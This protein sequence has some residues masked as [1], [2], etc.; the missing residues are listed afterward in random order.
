MRRGF[1]LVELI[2]VIVIVAIA[3]SVVLPVFQNRC[4]EPAR[5]TACA[6]NLGQIGKAL[7]MYSDVPSNGMFPTCSTDKND[8]YSDPNPMLALN[9][10]YR[11]YVAD[12]RVFS[13]SRRADVAGKTAGARI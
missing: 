5:R 12:A 10:L 7:M 3:A 2:V 8:P 9:L 11:G 13:C 4:R 1:T 6:S